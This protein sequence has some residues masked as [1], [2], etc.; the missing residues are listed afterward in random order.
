MRHVY[1]LI[2]GGI[3]M[4]F[5]QFGYSQTI[6]TIPYYT[7]IN[8]VFANVN[9]STITTGCL[10]DYGIDFLNLDNYTGTAVNDSN[11]VGLIEWR[12]LYASIY[13]EQINSNAN[14][15]YLDTLNKVFNNYAAPS[16]P[17]SFTTLYFTYQYLDSNAVTNHLM[18]VTNNQIFDVAGRTQSPYDKED[19]FAIAP[20]RQSVNIGTN[21]LEFPSALFFGNSAKTISTIQVDPLGTGTYQ[22]ATVNTPFNVTYDTAGFYNINHCCPDKS[23]FKNLRSVIG[24]GYR[25]KSVVTN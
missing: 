20:I 12:N 18:T 2:F 7:K 14:L 8:S 15:L 1:R 21:Q 25:L 4:L 9:T 23:G 22:T 17:I 6:D 5:A 19:L 3:L 11:F 10:R 24:K 16:L 13:S